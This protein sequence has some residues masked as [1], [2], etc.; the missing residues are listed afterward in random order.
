M[1]RHA[2]VALTQVI[3]LQCGTPFPLWR[4]AGHQQ[5][6]G[7]R[8]NVWCIT[9]Q[10]VTLH[11]ECPEGIDPSDILPDDSNPDTPHSLSREPDC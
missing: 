1:R 11:A 10:A 2:R 7:H 9:C 6:Q 4:N 3:C 5:R 8:K